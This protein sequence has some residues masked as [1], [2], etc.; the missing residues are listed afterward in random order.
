MLAYILELWIHKS[1][2]EKSSKILQ[3]IPHTW[4]ALKKKVTSSLTQDLI[5]V[6]IEKNQMLAKFLSYEFTNHK[7]K[8]V[9]KYCKKY[10][11]LEEEHWVPQELGCG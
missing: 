10:H 11:I 6:G 7:G 3:E 1:Q 4:G 9:V 8:K 2:R 5:I